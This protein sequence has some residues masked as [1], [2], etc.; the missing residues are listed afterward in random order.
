[1]FCL[2]TKY[3]SDTER[4][5]YRVQ[6]VITSAAT[7]EQKEDN[8]SFM[9]TFTCHFFPQHCS[10]SQFLTFVICEQSALTVSK[11]FLL[12]YVSPARR[13]INSFMISA[14]MSSRLCLPKH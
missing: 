2:V 11:L 5:I 3:I 6:D 14:G 1:M 10:C 12:S 8:D 7:G 9:D 13:L 4:V